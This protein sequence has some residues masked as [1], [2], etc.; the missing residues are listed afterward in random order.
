MSNVKCQNVSVEFPARVSRLRSVFVS[1]CDRFMSS[2]STKISSN[3]EVHPSKCCR[4]CKK[5]VTCQGTKVPRVSLFNII[6]NKELLAY[7][8]DDYLV[9]ADVVDSLGYKLVRNEKL[10]D[11]S[12]L[13]CART[14]ARI[15]G[16][17]KKV[18]AQAND[19]VVETPRAKRISR[20]SPTGISPAAKRTREHLST[21]SVSLR[22][23][24]RSL[25][26]N[27]VNRE[28]QNPLAGVCALDDGLISAMD[29]GSDVSNQPIMKVR[30]FPSLSSHFACLILFW[31]VAIPD[32]S[33]Q[34]FW[35]HF[36]VLNV[37]EGR[38]DGLTRLFRNLQI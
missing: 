16:T 36:R 33:L 5:N 22:S 27:D 6:R 10:S 29:L 4:F 31:S 26:L 32:Q 3:V 9:L 30:Y 12:C 25:A 17:F 8:D 28:N 11:V 1:S 19:G 34:R 14:L 38:E 35:N 2:L 21:S 24:R 37:H 13:T 7:S 18:T 23:P 15:Y 20:N